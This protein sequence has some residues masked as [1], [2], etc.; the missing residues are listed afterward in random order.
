MT[1][2]ATRGGQRLSYE[3]AGA[4]DGISVLALHDLLAD[5]G[6]LRFLAEAVPGDDVRLTLPDARGHGASPLISGRA[7]PARELAADAL[8]VLAAEGLDPARTHIVASGWAAETA[9]TL[10]LVLA[11][12]DPWP[13]ASITFVEPFFPALLADHPDAAARAAGIRQLEVIAHAADAAMKG[14]TDRAL[15]LL[16][17]LRLGDSWREG[18]P[19][20]RLGAMRRAAASLAPLLHGM[21]AGHADLEALRDFPGSVT[22]LLRAD[23]DV[24]RWTAEA[25]GRGLPHATIQQESIA[26]TTTGLSGANPEWIAALARPVDGYRG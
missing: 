18:L 1:R 6:Q 15:D 11:A 3:S 14:G 23:D 9:L 7:Y 10:V 22:I 4:T 16:M 24:Q 26:K 19:K 8:A 20:A 12:S 21:A 17:G 13:A 5:R 25:L 2:F